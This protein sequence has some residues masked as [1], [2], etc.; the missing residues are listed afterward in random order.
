MF[1]FL[2]ELEAS[3]IAQMVVTYVVAAACM[4]RCFFALH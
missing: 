2:G 3:G 4:T 1:P